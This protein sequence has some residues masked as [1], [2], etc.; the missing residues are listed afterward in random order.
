[1]EFEMQEDEYTSEGRELIPLHWLVLHSSL[2]HF[3]HFLIRPFIYVCLLM[4][5]VNYVNAASKR[6]SINSNVV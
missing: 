4:F 2:I 6:M 3:V 5:E 1:M